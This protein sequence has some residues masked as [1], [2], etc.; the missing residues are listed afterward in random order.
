MIAFK[1]AGKK[2]SFP[3]NLKSATLISPHIFAIG[4]LSSS[5]YRRTV[6]ESSSQA[7]QDV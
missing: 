6:L 3:S 2:N 5:F 7:R 4:W 1:A